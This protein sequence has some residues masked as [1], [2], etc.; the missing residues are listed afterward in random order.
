M[1]SACV[2]DSARAVYV[3]S[4]PCVVWSMSDSARQ[5]SLAANAVAIGARSSAPVG[6]SLAGAVP[7]Q[8][9][10]RVLSGHQ[11]PLYQLDR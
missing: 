3:A 9:G 11:W 4:D 10:I 5:A 1:P 6:L 7:L 8:V 2:T